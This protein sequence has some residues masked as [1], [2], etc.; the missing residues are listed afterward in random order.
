MAH[1][2]VER[3][4][5][6]ARELRKAGAAALPAIRKALEQGVHAKDPK[7]RKALANLERAIGES[8]HDAN[9]RKRALNLVT[10]KERDYTLD[11]VTA[12]LERQAKIRFKVEAEGP[13][14]V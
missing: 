11:E 5:Q 13:G 9:Q 6:A 1:E 10:L 14:T 4:D 7:A 12:D 2:L 3:Q 8:L